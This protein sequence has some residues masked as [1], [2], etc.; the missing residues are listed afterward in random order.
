MIK[1]DIAPN[2]EDLNGKWAV[3]G[4]GYGESII[5]IWRRILDEQVALGIQP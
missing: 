2:F 3:P 1:R 5:N 4:A